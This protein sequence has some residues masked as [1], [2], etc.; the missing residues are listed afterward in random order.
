MKVK[1]I[2]NT[3]KAVER[4]EHRSPIWEGELEILDKEEYLTMISI[5]AD[6]ELQPICQIP[7]AIGVGHYLWIPPDPSWDYDESDYSE[8]AETAKVANAIGP[9]D[10]ANDTG[11]RPI[12]QSKR[13]KWAFWK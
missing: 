12:H 7:F 10:T 3:R 4:G 5:M 1:I 8:F 6:G 9:S 11:D 13:I 2:I